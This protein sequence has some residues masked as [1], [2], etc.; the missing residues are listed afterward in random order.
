M[1]AS[2]IRHHC[3]GILVVGGGGPTHHCP[4]PLPHRRRDKR[5]FSLRDCCSH[6]C[7]YQRSSFFCYAPLRPYPSRAAPDCLSWLAMGRRKRTREDAFGGMFWHTRSVAYVCVCYLPPPSLHCHASV[8]VG[9]HVVIQ[10][11]LLYALHWAHRAVV[12]IRA[13][14]FLLIRRETEGTATDG[15][16]STVLLLTVL[17]MFSDHTLF[18]SNSIS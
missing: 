1:R 18:R 2:P 11:S 3:V 8:C 4:M 17:S 6:L 10:L 9:T 7:G 13:Q 5:L 12:L 16:L 14:N 15:T